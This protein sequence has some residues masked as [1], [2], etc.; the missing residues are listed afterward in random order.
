MLEADDFNNAARLDRTAK[1]CRAEGLRFGHWETWPHP[2]TTSQYIT[3]YEP[4]FVILEAERKNDWE[5]IREALP[6]GLNVSVC[7][8]L[9]EHGVPNYFNP[10]A[11]WVCHTECYIQD[12]PQATPPRM[13]FQA[14][15]V[16]FTNMIQPIFAVHGGL[17]LANYSE[18]FDYP[19]WSVWSAE[20][21]FR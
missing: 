21:I 5:A 19:G 7:T 20:Y 13:E 4:D 17:T 2:G 14:R 11:D 15:Q 1:A 6:S 12:N 10:I 18:W 16:G 9:D 8:N 3:M